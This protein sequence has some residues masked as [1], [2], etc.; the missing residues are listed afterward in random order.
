MTKAMQPLSG[1]FVLDFT[2]L[3]PGPLS[4]LTDFTQLVAAP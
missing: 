2:T 3:L 4:D 1:L